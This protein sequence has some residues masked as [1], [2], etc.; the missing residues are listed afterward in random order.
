MTAGVEFTAVMTDLVKKKKR[1]Q[2]N[3]NVPLISLPS[4]GD[5]DDNI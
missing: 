1:D 3:N 2:K 4:G 5:S